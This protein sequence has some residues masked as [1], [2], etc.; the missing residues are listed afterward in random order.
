MAFRFHRQV[1]GRDAGRQGREGQ[2]GQQQARVGQALVVETEQRVAD[3]RESVEG[4]FGRC[5]VQVG[6]AL[7]EAGADGGEPEVDVEAA[8]SR[9]DEQRR[10]LRADGEAQRRVVGADREVDRGARPAG[11]LLDLVPELRTWEG[12]RLQLQVGDVQFA[13]GPLR[14]GDPVTPVGAARRVGGHAP[15]A[16][17][18]AQTPGGQAGLRQPAVPD[19]LDD[20]A[21]D[22]REA[23]ERARRECVE[24][25]G[26]E[27]REGRQPGV[28]P[29]GQVT[30]VHPE[31]VLEELVVLVLAQR[32]VPALGEERVDEVLDVD[33][34]PDVGELVPL[35]RYG[36]RLGGREGRHVPAVDRFRDDREA[37]GQ[38]VRLCREQLV[39]VV[40]ALG[41]AQLVPVEEGAGVHLAG[42]QVLEEQ[43]RVGLD[44]VEGAVLGD[45]VRHPRRTAAVVHPDPLHRA[46][47]EVDLACAVR[48]E[49][50]FHGTGGEFVVAVEEHQERRPRDL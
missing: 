37:L 50:Q 40:D 29:V 24:V 43:P 19:Q 3:S 38:A 6:V 41:E 36:G 28:V 14:L 16:H 20:D 30:G 21:F 12:A 47:R 23:G 15:R 44:A 9:R 18:V 2:G 22:A 45:Q 26:D 46:H 7:E 49:Q 39:L 1:V 42:G 32:L 48:G 31:V 13:A 33:P 27:V 5:E 35:V 11:D 10:A 34:V 4:E 8:A 17:R 25:G